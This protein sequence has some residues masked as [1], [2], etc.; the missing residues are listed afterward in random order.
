[1]GY[2]SGQRDLTVTQLAQ[3]SGV[4]IPHPPPKS[5]AE[6][7]GFCILF[8]DVLKNGDMSSE[9][10]T[11]AIVI[12]REA[13]ALASKLTAGGVSEL[14]TKSSDVDVVTLVDQGVESLIRRMVSE[15]YPD[16]GFFGEEE[17]RSKSFSGR[18]WLVDPIDGTTNLLYGIPQYGVSI[19]VVE[20]DP[21]DWDWKALVGVVINP[22][23]GDEY[24]AKLGGGAFHNGESISINRPKSLAQSLLVTGFSYSA[25]LRIKQ[26]QVLTGIIGGVRDIRR[27]GACSLDLCA[28]ASGLVDVYFERTLSAWDFA[29]GALIAQEAGALVRGWNGAAPSHDWLLAGHPEIVDEFEELA[30]RS[31]ARFSLN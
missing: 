8:T 28:L 7:R 26:A 27:F 31:G 18:T 10:L 4:R 5:P 17:G 20:G 9:L 13:A 14:A 24:W 6:N 16:D 3:P 2:P 22:A 19:A 21:A 15:R 1:M 29:A 23:T 12:A 30:V 25:E 11:D